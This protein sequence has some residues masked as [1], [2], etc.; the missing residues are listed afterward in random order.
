VG[1]GDGAVSGTMYVMV[2]RME[3]LSDDEVDK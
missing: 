2:T 1:D 3:I